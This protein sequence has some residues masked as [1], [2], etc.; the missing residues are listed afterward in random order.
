MSLT[1]SMQ[2]TPCFCLASMLVSL[3][4]FLRC[5]RVCTLLTFLPC[6]PET[7][8]RPS[9]SSLFLHS[10]RFYWTQ[11]EHWWRPIRME[12]LADIESRSSQNGKF[13]ASCLSL[14]QSCNCVVG[15]GFLKSTPFYWICSLLMLGKHQE[16]G[17]H[18]LAATEWRKV[19]T[20]TL[21]SHPSP[22]LPLLLLYL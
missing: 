19:T 15:W 13:L 5:V 20:L 2:S 16:L 18:E 8:V 14:L 6:C 21:L 3:C 4:P 17:S 22:S 11:R 7:T 10:Q 12:C 1:I 9:F